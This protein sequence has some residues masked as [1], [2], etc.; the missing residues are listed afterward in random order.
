[1]YFL[2]EYNSLSEKHET[3]CYKASADMKKLFDSELV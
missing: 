3:I 1:M 2:I